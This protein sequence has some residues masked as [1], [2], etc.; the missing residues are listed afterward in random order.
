MLTI[1]VDV[2]TT[3]TH[4]TVHRVEAGAPASRGGGFA[5]VRT[6]V[7]ESPVWFTPWEGEGRLDAKALGR[8]HREGLELAGIEPR[9]IAAGAAIVTGEAARSGNVDEAME[10][11]SG[12]CGSMVSVLAGGRTESVLTGRG[13]GARDDS[14]DRLRTTAC[15][16]IGGGTANIAVFRYG[17]SVGAC[18]LRIGGRM[19]RFDPEGRILS[20]T[21]TA[22]ALARAGGWECEPGLLP[23]PG[24]PTALAERAVDAI[25][26]CLDGAEVD[27]SIEDAPW[28]ARPPD[29]PDAIFV[30]GGVGEVFHRPHLS[31]PGRYRDLGT[32]LA[33]A[34]RR[35]LPQAMAVSLPR[36]AVRATVVG[37]G[38]HSIHLA[39][40][41][42]HDSRNG[43]GAIRNARLVWTD[44]DGMPPD[45]IPPGGVAWRFGFGPSVEFGRLAASARQVVRAAR[46]RGDSTVLAVMESDLAK[47]YSVALRQAC[48]AEG[49]ELGL[50]CLDG[51]GLGDAELLDVGTAQARGEIPVV[52]RTLVFPGRP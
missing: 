22:A 33:A 32:E 29:G 3:T 34:L 40:P 21:A 20:R 46:E 25:L 18:N 35:K 13:C 51:L 30:T 36:E 43:D 8:L 42:V 5:E 28:D 24:M 16:D 17:E 38:I 23:A 4:F 47:A 26:S 9:R 2:G 52:A 11:L 14:R 19:V 45:W 15:L 6:K 41:T 39:G 27:P 31:D 50:V 7:A 37:V 44:S 48:A 49:I 12:L 1:G 10:S